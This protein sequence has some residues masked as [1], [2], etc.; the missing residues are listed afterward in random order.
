[1]V[2]VELTC[3][4]CDTELKGEVDDDVYEVECTECGCVMELRDCDDDS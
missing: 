2:T 4:D 1:M 3:A